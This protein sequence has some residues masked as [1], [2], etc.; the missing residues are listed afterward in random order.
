LPECRFIPVAANLGTRYASFLAQVMPKFMENFS[1]TF[2]KKGHIE[3]PK[4]TETEMNQHS[5]ET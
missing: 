5:G 1:M 4:F 2:A 3:R